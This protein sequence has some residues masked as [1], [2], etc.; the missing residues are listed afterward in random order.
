MFL[1]NELYDICKVLNLHQ[2]F[3]LDISYSVHTKKINTQ[4]SESEHDT[5]NKK[6][7]LFWL[8][9]EKRIGERCFT[10]MPPRM[11]AKIPE[12]LREDQKLTKR[13]YNE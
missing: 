13:L 5:R 6:Y 8:K 11:F 9:V 7:Q 3:D 10:Y 4:K 12:N 1:S 2:L